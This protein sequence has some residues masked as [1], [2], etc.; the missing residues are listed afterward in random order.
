MKLRQSKKQKIAIH[1]NFK[2]SVKEVKNESIVIEEAHSGDILELNIG[3]IRSHFIYDYCRTCHSFQGSTIDEKMTI[4]EWDHFHV[5][6]YW[7][8]TAVT[9]A[10]NLDKI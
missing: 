5:N 8:W 9:R 4:Y 2:Y 6:R 3:I 10:R 1:V 7:I